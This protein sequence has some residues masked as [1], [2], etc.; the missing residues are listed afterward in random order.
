MTLQ[1]LHLRRKT[2]Q[3]LRAAQDQTLQQT[4]LQARREAALRA[5]QML[6][7][8]SILAEIEQLKDQRS[9]LEPQMATIDSRLKT[10]RQKLTQTPVE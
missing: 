8:A 3:P 6:L 7:R 2:D 1:T 4:L 10:L 9:V 5:E